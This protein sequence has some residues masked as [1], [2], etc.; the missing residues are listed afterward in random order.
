MV[1]L[2][3]AWLLASGLM[4]LGIGQ[5]RHKRWSAAGTI[6]WSAAAVMGGVVMVAN[7]LARGRDN[8]ATFAALSWCFVLF[9][10]P[11]AMVAAFS[12]RGVRDSLR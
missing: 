7:I 11:I 6:I 12:R 9:P 8:G 4:L 10:C 3:I 2:A 1:V 5:V